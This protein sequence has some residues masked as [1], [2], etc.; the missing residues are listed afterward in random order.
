VDE[1]V[2]RLKQSVDLV[3]RKNFVNFKRKRRF[4]TSVN[5]LEVRRF[6]SKTLVVAYCEMRK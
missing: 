2:Q 5:N 1:T 4:I 6:L 3:E